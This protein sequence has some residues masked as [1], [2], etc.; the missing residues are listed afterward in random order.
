MMAPVAGHHALKDGLFSSAS[1]VV[2]SAA[3]QK[4]IES[5]S[6]VISRPPALNSG[7]AFMSTTVHVA[8]RTSKIRRASQ[9]TR[10]LVPSARMGAKKRMPNSPWPKSAVPSFIVA[11]IPGPLLK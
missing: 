8:T 10:R 1:H 11:A 4:K 7:V 5:G 2:Q 6:M 9:K 3:V